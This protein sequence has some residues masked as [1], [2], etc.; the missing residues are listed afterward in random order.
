MSK[1]DPIGANPLAHS[2]PI[3]LKL[4]RAWHGR[5]VR[6]LSHVRGQ[7]KSKSRLGHAE[8]RSMRPLSHFGGLSALSKNRT[9]TLNSDL[10]HLCHTFVA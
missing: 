4:A 7:N 9:G 1:G 10:W 5:C 8:E 2:W 6:P 3:W